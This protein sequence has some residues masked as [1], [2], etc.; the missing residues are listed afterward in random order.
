MRN[1]QVLLVVVASFVA[2]AVPTAAQTEP[3]R[4]EI[5]GGLDT[6]FALPVDG[7]GDVVPTANIRVTTPLTRQFAIEGFLDAG[8]SYDSIGGLYGIQVKQRLLGASTPTR[9]VFVTYGVAGGYSHYGAED[10]HYTGPNGPEVYRSSAHTNVYKPIF[11]VVGGGIQKRVA[12]RLAVRVEGQVVTW[13][14]YTPLMVRAAAGVSIP[15]G[16]RSRH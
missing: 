12:N 3:R 16:R 4:V 10:Y 9:D 13:R 2:S 14:I 15:I 11:P 5:G 1:I 8:R 6:I 7:G